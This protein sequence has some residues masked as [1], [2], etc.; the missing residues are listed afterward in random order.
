MSRITTLRYEKLDFY[1]FL[2]FLNIVFSDV[3][4]ICVSIPTPLSERLYNEV[5]RI[6]RF[7]RKPKKKIK[8]L[9][10]S[11][12]STIKKDFLANLVMRLQDFHFY[13]WRLAFK[14]MFDKSVK[15]S[16]MLIRICCFRNITKC[17]EFSMRE[18]SLFTVSLGS[19]EISS[20]FF[21]KFKQWSEN[22]PKCIFVKRFHC[23]VVEEK[24]LK[25]TQKKEN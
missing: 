13:R 10:F 3:Y 23:V 11:S 18:P 15:I 24:E 4:D 17:G 6:W 12:D 2:I 1:K 25:N 16:S 21:L 22:A 5:S 7:R 9:L 8:I 14:S 20:E 19:C